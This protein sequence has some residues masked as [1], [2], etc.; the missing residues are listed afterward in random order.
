VFVRYALT[1]DAVVPAGAGKWT[2]VGTFNTIWTA[3]FPTTLDRMGIL[4][5]I[6]G[7]QSEQGKHQLSLDLRD[8]DGNLIT[9]AK[10]SD[11]VLEAPPPHSPP[12]FEFSVEM[13][14]MSFPTEGNY[15]ISIR[16]DNKFIDSIP[17]Y[18]RPIPLTQPDL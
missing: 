14:R 7:H 4:V 17:L 8:H 10:V 16:V 18:V 2:V 3:T 5:R 13:R 11:F 1:A 12:A 9:Q 15:D 6:E